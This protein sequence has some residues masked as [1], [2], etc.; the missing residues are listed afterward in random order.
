MSES[1]TYSDLRDNLKSTLDKVCQDHLPLM[2]RRQRG[3]DVV[4]LSKE[5]YEAL[6]E[7]AYLL[8]SPKNV[9]HLT[10]AIDDIERGNG[11]SF[12]SKE[13]LEDALGV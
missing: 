1:I 10:K 13:E 11:V 6:D 3:S 7:T 4:I 9:E 12:N 5:D 2:V 8:R